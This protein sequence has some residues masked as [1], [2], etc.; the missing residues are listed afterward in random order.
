MFGD[1]FGVLLRPLVSESFRRVLHVYYGTQP[2]NEHVV[3]AERPR[4]VIQELVQR[5]LVESVVQ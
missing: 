5:A 3:A 1:S 2:F 4:V